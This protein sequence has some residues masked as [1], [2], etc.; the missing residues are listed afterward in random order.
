MVRELKAIKQIAVKD[1]DHF[2]DHRPLTDEKTDKL[3]G[4]TSIFMTGEKWRHMRATLSPAFTGSKMRQMFELV[5]DFF[6]HFFTKAKTRQKI[7]IEMKGFF[8]RYTNDVIASCAFG[9]TV[10]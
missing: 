1:L 8:S 2:K 7:K 6:K 5:A 4:N 9:L 10:N 3:W